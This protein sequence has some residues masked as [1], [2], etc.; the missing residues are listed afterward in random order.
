MSQAPGALI[1][2]P[3]PL[4]PT[5]AGLAR[6][7]VIAFNPSTELEVLDQTGDDPYVA[8]LWLLAHSAAGPAWLTLHQLAEDAGYSGQPGAE[9]VA[10]EAAEILESLLAGADEGDWQIIVD[11]CGRPPLEVPYDELSKMALARVH[12]EGEDER[13]LGLAVWLD[14]KRRQQAKDLR[15]AFL[16]VLV[17]TTSPPDPSLEARRHRFEYAVTFGERLRAGCCAENVVAEER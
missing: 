16:G 2:H 9:L 13:M 10:L 5:A 8:L 7:L 4:R 12:R 17:S 14:G 1:D 6:L 3:C 11:A 15:N